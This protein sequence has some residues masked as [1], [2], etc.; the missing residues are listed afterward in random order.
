M[1]PVSLMS[2]QL[3]VL[4]IFAADHCREGRR[5]VGGD[6]A[7][8]VEEPGRFTGWPPGEPER[9][10]VPI[11][12]GALTERDRGVV[13]KGGACLNRSQAEAPKVVVPLLTSVPASK[14]NCR[15]T[16]RCAAGDRHRAGGVEAAI[17]GERA[18]TVR[19]PEPATLPSKVGTEM[20][21][22]VRSR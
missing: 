12:G 10:T 19:L 9:R 2:R 17:A 21:F 14:S 6:G 16:E 18:V 7:G 20:E 1:G 15:Y 13:V 11:Y 8:V 3:G 22:V 5:A 4:V